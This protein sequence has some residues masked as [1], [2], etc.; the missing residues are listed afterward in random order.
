VLKSSCPFLAVF[1]LLRKKTKAA[2]KQ[3][4]PITPTATAIP[5]PAFAPLLSPP[6][7]VFDAPVSLEEEEELDVTLAADPGVCVAP[8]AELVDELAK[9][10]PLIWTP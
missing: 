10:Q 3:Q 8:V 1:F 7:D 9:F 2:T 4:I 6:F 5:I